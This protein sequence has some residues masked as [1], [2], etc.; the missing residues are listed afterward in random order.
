MG[1]SL[2]TA[3]LVK[4]GQEELKDAIDELE[5]ALPYLQ[6]KGAHREI[7]TAYW[8][9]ADIYFSLKRKKLA[10]DMLENCAGVVKELGYDHFLVVEAQ[11]NPLLVAYGSANKAA[12]GYYSRVQRL[13]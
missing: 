4:R 3:G 9:L 2:M 13:I 1:M 10:L 12:D 6:N 11:R 8:Y 7:A 5:A